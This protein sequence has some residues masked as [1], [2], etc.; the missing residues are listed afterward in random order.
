MYY[1]KAS[2]QYINESTPF[3]IDDIQYPANWLQLANQ[4]EIKDA[5]LSPV[6]YNGEPKD[7]LYYWVSTTQSNGVIT[8]TNKP[9][10]LNM[11]KTYWNNIIDSTAY[12]MLLPSDWMVVKA[13]ETNSVVSAEWTAYRT[14]VRDVASAAKAAVALCTTVDEVKQAS[15]FTWPEQPKGV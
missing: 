11:L 5:G 3:V 7:D 1:H 15:N 6:T 9:K 14:S 2:D 10:D 8:Y 13:L 12:K 4:N